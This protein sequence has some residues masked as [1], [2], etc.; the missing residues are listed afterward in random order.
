[1]QKYNPNLIG[2]QSGWEKYENNPVIGEEGD[3]F[4]DNHVL[5]VDGKYIMYFSTRN[6]YSIAMTESEDGVNWSEPILVIEPRSETGW[7]DDINRP[8]VVY[9]DNIYHMW[10]SGQT[11]GKEFS[12]E[13]WTDV[14]L[15]ASMNKKGTSYIGYAT[16]KDGVNWQRFDKP[17]IQPTQEWEL[18]SLM[19]PTAIWDEESQLFKLWYSGGEWF[20]PNSIGYAESV[21]GITWRK[22]DNN[23][24]FSA[25]SE[26]IWERERVAGAHVVK[27]DGWYHLFYIGY[28]DLFKARISLAR[29]KDGITEWERHQ[30]NPIISPGLPGS[31]ECEAIYKP[32]VL[33][34][35]KEDCW[36]M[37]YNARKGT[38][39]RIGV[40][41]HIGKDLGFK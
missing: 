26:N 39:E 25:K 11:S 4:F 36:I 10:Y 13:V 8:T 7:E 22:H 18:N 41:Y 16:S 3:F 5:K 33:Y 38:S 12:S 28:E 37:W 19:C 1:M 27:T 31:W 14:Y 29:S 21:D 17:V 20:E 6:N 32:F 34:E 15:E 24:I 40:A 9:K 35:K 23:P 2:C 30:N